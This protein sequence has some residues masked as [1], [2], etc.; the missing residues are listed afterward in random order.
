[1]FWVRV[2]LK[3][4]SLARKLNTKEQSPRTKLLV[5]VGI[6]Q[7]LSAGEVDFCSLG[8]KH[9]RRMRRISDVCFCQREN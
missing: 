4:I 5:P 1:M 7:G 6:S 8:S 3:V 9:D 2:P